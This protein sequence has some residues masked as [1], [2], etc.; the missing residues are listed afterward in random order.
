MISNTVEHIQY[1]T[2]REEDTIEITSLQGNALMS[3]CFF[4]I[5][6]EG[7]SLLQRTINL[8]T[9]DNLS[10]KD[11]MVGPNMSFV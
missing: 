7:Q 9:K 4:Q 11:K 8:S 3:T 6:F 1:R 5:H 2:I 10:A